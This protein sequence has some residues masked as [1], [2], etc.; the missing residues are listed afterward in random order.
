MFSPSPQINMSSAIAFT[1]SNPSRFSSILLQNSS[2]ATL[3]PK[4]ILFHFIRP[5]GVLK[6]VSKELSASNG[7]CQKAVLISA[8]ENTLALLNTNTGMQE[9][10]SASILSDF[11]ATDSSNRTMNK[12]KSSSSTAMSYSCH[13]LMQFSVVTAQFQC[14]YQMNLSGFR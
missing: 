14:Q 13:N 11:L 12:S 1:P 4:G 10:M 9:Q 2:G 5:R 7:T 8:R 3:M 6:V